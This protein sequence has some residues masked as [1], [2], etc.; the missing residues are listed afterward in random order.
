MNPDRAFSIQNLESKIQNGISYK[1]IK[2]ARQSQ[3]I[4]LDRIRTTLG[5][6]MKKVEAIIRP[7]KLDEVK[8]A[9]VNAG[10]VGMTVSEVRG[11]GRQK[12]QTERY[13]GSEYTVEF[14]QKLKVEIVV[15][16]N[17][18]DMVVDKII[19]SCSY[20]RNW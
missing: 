16:D 15:E 1:Q 8:I 4:C 20:W 12:G 18:V 9:L 7:F 2:I 11:F 14:L 13:R 6:K 3:R 17:Q 19:A 5:E 10:I